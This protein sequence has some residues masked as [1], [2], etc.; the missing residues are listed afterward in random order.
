MS[1]GNAS[2][3][4]NNAALHRYELTADGGVAYLEYSMQEGRIS[5]DHTY[6]PDIMRGK[7]AG[8]VLVRA[9][10]EE[11]KHNGWSIVPQC[12]FVAAFLRKHAAS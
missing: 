4:V 1:G 6:V 9:A 12:T 2:P 7:G 10:L 11:A 8:A 5:L 3:V